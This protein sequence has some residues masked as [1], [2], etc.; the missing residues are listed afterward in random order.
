MAGLQEF[1]APAAG[2]HT[3]VLARRIRIAQSCSS[4]AY[5]GYRLQVYQYDEHILWHEL[6]HSI[7]HNRMSGSLHIRTGTRRPSAVV[8]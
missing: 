4:R 1:L 2:N 3:Q 8:Q 7:H 5:A 6:L